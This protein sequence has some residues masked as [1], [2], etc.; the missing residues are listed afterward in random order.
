MPQ[1]KAESHPDLEGWKA[2]ADYLAQ[3]VSVVQRWAKDGMPV[4]RKGRYVTASPDEL[5]T[6]L[7]KE[8][9]IGLPAHISGGEE[10]RDDLKQSLTAA[11]RK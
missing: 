11:K 2:I 7:G 3:P 1:K 8:E 9:G 6:W 5:R 10:L 4:T